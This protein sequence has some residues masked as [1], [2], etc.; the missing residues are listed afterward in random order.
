MFPIIQTMSLLLLK[1]DNVSHPQVAIVIMFDKISA[2]QI[3][4]KVVHSLRIGLGQ[5]YKL[6]PIYTS[7]SKNLFDWNLPG[8][9][10]HWDCVGK[11]TFEELQYFGSYY[12][13]VLFGVFDAHLFI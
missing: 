13:R 3:A 12:A 6:S 11:G 10:V 4:E 9:L 7:F 5:S 8:Q 1:V 2:Q